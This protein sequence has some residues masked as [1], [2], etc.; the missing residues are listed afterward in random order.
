MRRLL[1]STPPRKRGEVISVVFNPQPLFPAVIAGN[2]QREALL[3]HRNPRLS[4]AQQA[5]EQW[6]NSKRTA[7]RGECVPQ[8]AK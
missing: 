6:N 4:A 1:V 8:R 3:R 5:K 2:Y 7:A